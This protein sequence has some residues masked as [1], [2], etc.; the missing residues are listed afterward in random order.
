MLT[1]V[2]LITRSPGSSTVVHASVSSLCT[3]TP[4]DHGS[5]RNFLP[6]AA[7]AGLLLLSPRVGFAVSEA[8]APPG[9]IPGGVSLL[10]GGDLSSVR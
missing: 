9:P 1:A 6:S 4:T 3:R 5:H 10:A 8:T 2:G 7:V